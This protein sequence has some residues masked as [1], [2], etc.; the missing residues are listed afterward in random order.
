[1]QGYVTELR[2]TLEVHPV[3]AQMLKSV[4]PKENVESERPFGTVAFSLNVA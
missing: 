3:L 4:E 2:D 1:M